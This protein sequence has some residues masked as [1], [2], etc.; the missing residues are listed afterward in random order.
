MRFRADEGFLLSIELEF[1]SCDSMILVGRTMNDAEG[2]GWVGEG[3]FSKVMW[4]LVGK[5]ES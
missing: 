5:E 1:H 2:S 4:C 3:L